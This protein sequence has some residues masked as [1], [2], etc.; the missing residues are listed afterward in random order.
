MWE[1][2]AV[3]RAFYL[4]LLKKKATYKRMTWQQH[5]KK[6]AAEYQ[7]MKLAN[8]NA[9]KTKARTKPPPK[10][11]HRVRGKK[12]DPQRDIN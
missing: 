12:V 5:L 7:Q 9:Q 8:K 3:H 6:C 10:V 1:P 2:A 4:K 11:P